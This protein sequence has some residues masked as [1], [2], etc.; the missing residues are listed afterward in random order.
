MHRSSTCVESSAKSYD[1]EIFSLFLVTNTEK[2]KND[3]L[4]DASLLQL[5][6]LVNDRNNQLT[7]NSFLTMFDLNDIFKESVFYPINNTKMTQ[8]IQT[9]KTL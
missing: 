1:N 7:N 8:W 6:F 5:P 2:T 4:N 3:V 9:K